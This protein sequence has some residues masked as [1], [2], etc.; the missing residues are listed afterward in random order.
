MKSV[1]KTWRRILAEVLTVVMTFC[2]PG[3]GKLPQV[4]A[5]SSIDIREDFNDYT[6][7]NN[8]RGFSF[9]NPKF[10]LVADGY[11]HTQSLLVKDRTANYFG[12]AYDLSAF[13]GNSITLS[14]KAAEYGVSD[15]TDHTIKAT[16]QTADDQFNQV[17]STAFNGTEF[18]DVT[19]E[20]DIPAGCSVYN[21]YFE[22]EENVSYLLDD[23]TIEVKGEYKDPSI[24][25]YV[26]Y[27]GY[28]QLKD[29]YKDYFK[30]GMACETISNFKKSLSEIGN[31]NKEGLI[32]HEFN[33]ITAG[34]EMKP[35]Y[36]MGYEDPSAREDYLPFVIN[37]SAKEMLDW[38][39]AH[40]MKMRGHVLVWHSQCADEV[41]CKNYTP[42]K[43]ANDKL[44]PSCYVSRETM[45]KRLES[46]ID[47]TMEYM[48]KNHYADTL[49]A[50][51]VVNEAIEPS[52][53]KQYGLRNSYWY[54]VIG[55]DFMYY[56]FKYAREAVN[57][58]SKEYANL[59]DIDPNDAEALKAIQPKLYY[60]DY[61]EWMEEKQNDIIAA[62]TTAMNGHGSIT[63]DGY[64]DGIGM[65][66]HLSDNNKV[67][68]YIQAMK[69]Y[70]EI[71]DEVQVTELDVKRTGS[72]SNANYYQAVFYNELFKAFIQA[73][74]DGVNL[75]AVTIWGLTDDNS[76]IQNGYPLLFEGDLSKKK[77]FDGVVYAITG[78]SLGEPEFIE[79]DL[80]DRI[81][82][83]EPEDG[84]V[85]LPEAKDTGFI[86]RGSGTL[87]VQD[88]EVCAG[89]GSL[90]VSNRTAT[91]NGA[92]FSVGDY[93]GE[94]IEVSAW[95]KS[96]APVVKL[97]ADINDSWPNIAV[98]DTTSGEWVQIKG[99]YRVPSDMATLNLYLETDQEKDVY[100]DI[101][102]DEVRIHRVG[103]LE[104]FEDGA[105]VVLPRG[106]GHQPSLNLVENSINS[107]S[108][109][110]LSISR[111]EKDATMK[112]PVSAYIGKTISVSAYVKTSDGKIRMG[113][114][115][116]TPTQF[117]EV[118]AGEDWTKVETIITIPE[119]MK[120]AYV[121]IETD[122]NAIYYVDEI[123]AVLANYSDDVEGEELKFTTRWGGAGTVSRVEDGEGNHAAVL[124]DRAENYYGISFDVSQYLG[125]TVK[126]TADVK[127]DDAVICLTG[128]ISDVW[129]N[130]LRT[131]SNPGQ[132]KTIS[133][134]ASLPKNL[135]GLKLYFESDGKSDIYVDNLK[136]EVV[137]LD[138]EARVVFSE[139]G[140]GVPADS[141]V[142]R[143]GSTVKKP[144]DPVAPGYEFAGWYREPEV[145]TEWD[146]DVDT[147]SGSAILYAK[148]TGDGVLPLVFVDSDAYDI[149]A[150]TEGVSILPIS[151]ADAVSGGVLPYRFTAFGLPT[152][153]KIS[154]DG[155]ISG[156]PVSSGTAGTAMITVT[157]ARMNNTSIIINFAAISTNG[158]SVGPFV[159]IPGDNYDKK[160]F[161]NINTLLDLVKD[162]KED[163]EPVRVTYLTYGRDVLSTDVIAKLAGTNAVL[164][165][166]NMDGVEFEINCKDLDVSKVKKLD[167]GTDLCKDVSKDELA[168]YFDTVA[169]A[170]KITVKTKE[171]F[172]RPIDMKL[173]LSQLVKSEEKEDKKQVA[174]LYRKDEKTGE[175]M[176]VSVSNLKDKK[177]VFK[178][179][180]GG[181]YLAVVSGQIYISEQ[182]WNTTTVKAG[183]KVQKNLQLK[184]K[185]KNKKS[186]AITVQLPAG[187]QGM[188]DC[189]FEKVQIRY[190]SSDTKVAMVNRVGTVTAKGKG[191]AVITATVKYGDVV[192]V[193]TQK[194]TV[195]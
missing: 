96:E 157:D 61:N 27:S 158:G 15:V 134:I 22:S 58:W 59:Y 69:K 166:R 25:N 105:H 115:E 82:N 189:K 170:E 71:V 108:G 116:E 107:V 97:S 16:L 118:V 74:K 67:E 186:A 35:A 13:A 187:I 147:V 48:Y 18:V 11:N 191:S 37:P 32:L 140:H 30:M 19:G 104:G 51:D 66:G 56:A 109:H 175:L 114:D 146:F 80:S 70:D 10:E 173:D 55:E 64:I 139:N 81:F 84:N 141:Q 94:T 29:L 31:P 79:V 184:V 41:F 76:W 150:M 57:K 132:Y 113:L 130:Y 156:I 9:G 24:K 83:F 137:G 40:G 110:A 194:V 68:D 60:N 145:V 47:T 181:T 152:G 33:S 46:Y 162:A 117:T 78:E 43:G 154:E 148:W 177:A 4:K 53:G 36:N 126:V 159:P 131:S 195:K 88:N 54:Q 135:S 122:G 182:V 112:F 160:E 102:I 45:L 149:P 17:A 119:T 65:Q 121:F 151:V 52:D 142:V 174:A 95:V 34:N 93:V 26:D 133:A 138:E 75:T 23:V 188:V 125:M 89:K 3:G 50:W 87:T 99:V 63:G 91:W 8:L 172:A 136:V 167:F 77:A 193:F 49:Y 28:P 144:E 44:D 12:Y 192:K 6:D 42:V 185:N 127:T 169:A 39:E 98:V 129:P 2:I 128:D 103:L 161:S 168:D 123:Q 62:L 111:E 90:K 106:V 85:T 153:I 163:E 178:I 86:V 5:E 155:I 14:A 180:S 183:D 21:L 190:S 176:L 171:A 20:Y 179:Q 101:Y 92:A 7:T 124:A 165:V 38:S 120:S 143:N 73:K 72:N 164:V 1:K 100:K